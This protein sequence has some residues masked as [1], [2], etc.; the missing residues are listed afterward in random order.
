MTTVSSEPSLQLPDNSTAPLKDLMRG[1]LKFELWGR[2]GWLEV[3]RRYRRTVLGPFWSSATLAIYTIAVGVVGAGLWHQD[4]HDYL[5]YLSSGM[6][7]W[8]FI[9]IIITE[10]CT[11]FVA[12]HALFRNVSFEYSI[13]AY[14]LVWRNFIVFAHNLAVYTLIVLVLKPSL[15]SPM[16]LMAIPGLFL[17]VAN[18]VWIALL[19]GMLCLRYRDLQ[20]MVQTAIQILMLIT[21]IFWLADTLSSGS[22][23]L[24]FVQLNPIYHLIEVVRAPLLARSPTSASYLFVVAMTI[25]GWA[26]AYVIFRKFRGRIS[27]WS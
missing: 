25:V 5:P 4:P 15:L 11:M 6:I 20:P 10:A 7:V 18:G 12:G 13:L 27:Y 24:V 8:T 22:L 23:S 14:S 3:K 21:P 9:S 17:V 1:L 26:I 2:I 19:V 16:T